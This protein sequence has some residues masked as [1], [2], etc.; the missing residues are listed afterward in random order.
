PMGK[1]SGWYFLCI[2]WFGCRDIPV[3]CGGPALYPPGTL[4]LYLFQASID[5]TD[6]GHGSSFDIQA[7]PEYVSRLGHACLARTASYVSPLDA[8]GET[9]PH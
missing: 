5:P 7:Y 9:I 8:R 1:S 3:T 6:S 4:L 2:H